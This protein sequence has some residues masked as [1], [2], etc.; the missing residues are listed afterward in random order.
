MSTTIVTQIKA[1]EGSEPTEIIIDD[2]KVTDIPNAMDRNGW[3]I[4]ARFMRKW[5]NEPE[6]VLPRKAKIGNIPPS[7]L[8][9]NAL[10]T[11][12][13]FEWL[14]TSSTRIK[15]RVDELLAS[16]GSVNNVNPYIGHTKEFRNQLSKGLVQFLRRLSR[17]GYV[18][19]H[20]RCLKDTYADFSDLSAIELEEK[21][22]F[23]FIPIGSTNIEKLTDDLDD[24]YGALG[25]FTIKM[26]ATRFRITSNYQGFARIEI[27]EIGLY[28]RDTY[29]FINDDGDDQFLGYW[30]H[31]GPYKYGASA[32][33][34]SIFSDNKTYLKATNNSFNA[35][36]KK[37]G[38]GCDFIVFS[39]VQKH[40]TSIAIYLNDNDI[41]EY[42]D[43]K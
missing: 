16:L 27:D 3:T 4:S 13:P 36:R 5:L 9:K 18:D 20:T 35:Y 24:V 7:A 39:T 14:L 29:D 21:S 2:F 41:K 19:E 33:L 28:V 15:P 26:A 11:D 6:Y 42:I 23:N 17:L 31:S 10:V 1:S 34:D 40:P 43:R 30:N 12:L 8:P 22:Q 32:K 38:K 37:T 25:N